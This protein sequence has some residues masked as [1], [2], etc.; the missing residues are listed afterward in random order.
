MEYYIEASAWGKVLSFLRNIKGLHTSNEM[1][2]RQFIEAVWYIARTGCQWRLLPKIYG[3]WRAVHGRFKSWSDK[4]IWLE[5]FKHFQINGDEEAFMID[6]TIVRAHACASGYKE[7]NQDQEAL[8]RSMGG[9]TTKI[10][11]LVDALGYPLKFILTPG[12]RQEITQAYELTEGISEALLIADKAYD[13]YRFVKHLEDKNCTPV[14]PSKKNRKKP[15]KHDRHA[16][17]ERHL[18]ECFFG[19]IKH[20]RR[21]FSRF[22]KTASVFLSFLHFVGTLIW[23]K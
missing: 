8:G 18:I 4:G 17:K 14:I 21:I 11:A 7:N 19:K 23:L 3:F 5:L 22:D 12:Q 9:F 16:Y 6:A 10:H 2:L 20:F 13:S 1:K 15:R